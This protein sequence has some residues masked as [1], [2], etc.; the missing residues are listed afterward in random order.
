[1][2]RVRQSG[3]R[4][5]GLLSHPDHIVRKKAYV[6]LLVIG[7]VGPHAGHTVRAAN[8][9]VHEL[10][11]ALA[12]QGHGDVGYLRIM[13]HTD[14]A[15]SEAER[16]GVTS[17]QAAGVTVL[18]ELRLAPPPAPR[19]AWRKLLASRRSD[20]YPESVFASVVQDAIASFQP[21]MIVVP[22]SEWITALCADLPVMKFAYY[23]NPDHK[24]GT[25][26]AMFERR[27]GIN[28]FS[29]LRVAAYLRMLEAQ[30]I[31]VVKQY[32]LLGDV[33][34]NDA[35]YYV[36]KGH[37]NA[38]YIQNIWI[39]RFGAEWP[40]LRELAAAPTKP[41]KI[42]VN[43][44]Q[45]GGTANRYG[46]E[47]LGKEVAPL[48]RS[49]LVDI[50]YELHILGMGELFESLR[51][52]LDSPEIKM[53]GF[54]DDI[55]QEM[56]EAAAFVCLNNASP[57]KVGHTRYLHAWSLGMCV[58]AHEDAALSM[59]EM[60]HRENC[61]LGGTSHEIAALIRE[62]IKEPAVRLQMGQNGY[63]TFRK[64]FIAPQVADKLWQ[65]ALDAYTQ[66]NPA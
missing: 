33:A 64:Y 17:L 54:V 47:I 43:V 28:R 23:G 48:L 29:P 35:A 45:L 9:V 59:P 10:V 50:P 57:F 13:R 39:D 40:R 14:P 34:A 16:A 8:V 66:M 51:L 21:D 6:K 24:A 5:P 18:D 32:E 1:M 41:A 2:S 25:Y 4:F 37:P 60:R 55:D 20:F 61:L 36:S 62:A 38:F 56:F 26:R 11:C 49:M 52:P 46:L 31:K 65:Y 19:Q 12:A 15:Q 42:I 3:Q 27:H 63:D 22:W 53:R 30:H 58:V 7:N 44:G